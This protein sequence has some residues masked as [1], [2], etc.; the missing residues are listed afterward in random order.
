MS[1]RILDMTD[2]SDT[3]IVIGIDPG[4]ACGVVSIRPEPHAVEVV[5]SQTMDRPATLRWLDTSLRDLADEDSILTVDPK[6]AVA[7]ERFQIAGRTIMGTREGALEALYTIGAADHIAATHRVPFVLQ[8]ASTT[9][10]A[11][12]DAYL[13]EVGLAKAT[14]GTH[15]RD[16]LRHA[17]LYA[18]THGLWSGVAA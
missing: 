5:F 15:E 16:A 1:I 2:R 10:N 7:I 4:K 13:R 18:R 9:K 17:L 8:Q 6:V 11:V 12:S 14:K 3:M